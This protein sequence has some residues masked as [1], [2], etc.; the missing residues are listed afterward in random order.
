MEMNWDMVSAVSEVA[1]VVAVVISLL[2]V[3]R[4]INMSNRLARAEASRTPTSDLNMLNAS[5]GPS[6]E[7]RAAL[8]KAIEGQER[9]AFGP[10]DRV[11]LDLYLVSVT[12]IYEQLSREVREGLL[13]EQSLDFGGK[14]LFEMP[15]YRSSWPILKPFLSSSFAADFEKRLALD[16]NA[17]TVY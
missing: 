6:H 2:Y 17:E 11:L 9:S 3:S 14:G 12:N 5:F 4:Q 8:R 7:F 15:F 10:D 16:P 1:G 13:D